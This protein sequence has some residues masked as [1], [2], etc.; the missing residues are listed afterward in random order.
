MRDIGFGRKLLLLTEKYGWVKEKLLNMKTSIPY[1]PEIEEFE[2]CAMR[3]IV[4]YLSHSLFTKVERYLSECSVEYLRDDS[5]D[6]EPAS[7]TNHFDGYTHWF[8]PPRIVK[9]RV[10]DFM[11]LT[12]LNQ[13]GSPLDEC[14]FE[15]AFDKAIDNLRLSANHQ[16]FLVPLWDVDMIPNKR[17]D[18]GDDDDDSTDA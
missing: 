12:L 10:V 17:S 9:E 16:P 4:A 1:G 6:S 3:L 13:N 5:D 8:R 15:S 7:R 11:C 2:V 18:D 14:S